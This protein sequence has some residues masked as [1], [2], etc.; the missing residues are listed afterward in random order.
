ML[1]GQCFAAGQFRFVGSAGQFLLVEI[2]PVEI[3]QVAV[4]DRNLELVFGNVRVRRRQPLP[5]GDRRLVARLRILRVALGAV[6]D[7]QVELDSGQAVLEFDVVAVF[8]DERFANGQRGLARG[9]RTA[10]LDLRR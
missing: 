10:R 2:L 6:D 7:R 4:G 1:L 3:A 9:L 8:V 5:N